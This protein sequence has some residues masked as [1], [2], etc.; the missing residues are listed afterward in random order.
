M[1]RSAEELPQFIVNQIYVHIQ[2]SWQNMMCASAVGFIT[3]FDV[4]GLKQE[5]AVLDTCPDVLARVTVSPLE[6]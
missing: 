2:V 1:H 3:F 6:D 5:V 4:A